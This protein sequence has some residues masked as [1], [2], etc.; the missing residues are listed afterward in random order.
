MRIGASICMAL[1][2]DESLSTKME[3]NAVL[4]LDNAKRQS[5]E[6]GADSTDWFTPAS[7]EARS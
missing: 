6:Q 5:N 1:T 7:I 4:A 3:R 2:G